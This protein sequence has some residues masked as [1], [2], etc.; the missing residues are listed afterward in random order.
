M[1][2]VML[3]N[4][5][6]QRLIFF[7][8]VSVLVSSTEINSQTYTIEPF[9]KP[10][11][12]L[13]SIQVYSGKHNS[14]FIAAFADTD[15]TLPPPLDYWIGY[16]YFYASKWNG[17]SFNNTY[18]PIDTT[19]Y[20]IYG[21]YGN[22]DEIN[23][24]LT[25]GSLSNLISAWV[26]QKIY[27]EDVPNTLYM[28]PSL[29]IAVEQNESFQRIV[30]IPKGNHPF[31][32]CDNSNRLHLTWE[33]T[34]PIRVF[35]S[36][37]QDSNFIVYSSS[38]SYAE[39]QSDGFMNDTIKV[40]KGFRP[41]LL[42]DFNNI[43]HFFWLDSDSSSS[44][45]FKI[46]NCQMA[47]GGLTNAVMMKDSIKTISQDGYWRQSIL[48]IISYFVDSIGNSYA[49]WTEFIGEGGILNFVKLYTDN[50]IE[51]YSKH[52]DTIF[53][54]KAGFY[55]QSDGTINCV[56]TEKVGEARCLNF[57][58]GTTSKPLFASIRS[59]QSSAKEF[60]LV[61]STDKKVHCVYEDGDI[62]G[63]YFLRDIKD[64]NNTCF[65]IIPSKYLYNYNQP[66]EYYHP[67]T[68]DNNDQVWLAYASNNISNMEGILRINRQI[69]DVKEIQELIPSN[70]YLSQNYPNPFN[71]ETI[72]NFH[73]SDAGFVTL[74]IFDI[75]GREISTLINEKRNPGNYSIP[76]NAKNL[77]SGVYFYRLDVSQS[78]VHR[79]DRFTSTRRMLLLK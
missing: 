71:P 43:L 62:G 68:I 78:G 60:Y 77:S 50:T 18:L 33:Q 36:P 39:V 28:E 24:S 19:H 13:G 69:T 27:W 63:I 49:A 67:V 70:F 20:S 10:L 73:L 44:T 23:F 11:N 15:Q 48:P 65:S 4:L 57:S 29:Q 42:I 40:G 66:K 76:F 47:P 58:Q 9:S 54:T 32:L 17:S 61:E 64:S 72:I 59:F 14:V 79:C 53:N 35:H 25:E 16:S 38:I 7:F 2:V 74:K 31:I 75:L 22:Y 34:N 26:K 41:R 1:V 30:N 6:F 52:I 5:H 37:R 21:L 8:F 55:V 3:N 12:K 45:Y 46:M 56:W 51:K